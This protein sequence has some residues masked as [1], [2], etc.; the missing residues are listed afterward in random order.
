MKRKV[1]QEITGLNYSSVQYLLDELDKLGVKP[2]DYKNWKFENDYSG[3]FYE[4][5]TPGIM[6][7]EVK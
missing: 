4:D 5:S 1:K 3:C 2:E 7:R 6:V